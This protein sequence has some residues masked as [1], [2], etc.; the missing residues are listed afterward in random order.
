MEVNGLS[1]LNYRLVQLYFQTSQSIP[2]VAN[3]FVAEVF[4]VTLKE[5]SV[6]SI[7]C[8]TRCHLVWLYYPSKK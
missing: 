1:E 3:S 6:E 8:F 7:T 4:A 5:A 2:H